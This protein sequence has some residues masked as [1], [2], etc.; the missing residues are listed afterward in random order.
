M[1]GDA[2]SGRIRACVR[3]EPMCRSPVGL[4]ETI[5]TSSVTVGGPGALGTADT[6]QL[7]AALDRMRADGS[8][9][10]AEF[11]AVKAKLLGGS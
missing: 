4:I 11:T 1:T 10:D 2:P 9:T 8:L 5:T 7:L 3:A 6:V